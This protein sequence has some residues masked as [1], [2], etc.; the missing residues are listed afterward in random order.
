MKT[1][2]ATKTAKAD[3]FQF[4]WNVS[5]TGPTIPADGIAEP[6]TTGSTLTRSFQYPGLYHVALT[7][8]NSKG[9]CNDNIT[10]SVAPP[11]AAVPATVDALAAAASQSSP[12]TA[13]ALN[14]PN[15]DYVV[16]PFEETGMQGGSQV[17][18]PYNAQIPYNSLNAQVIQNRGAQIHLDSTSFF[19]TILDDRNGRRQELG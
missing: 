8:S 7:G 9:S 2:A 14:A 19:D 13:S 3:P 6:T 12:Q 15:N 11:A 4:S 16:L 10:V 5:N 18:L 17:N 1:P